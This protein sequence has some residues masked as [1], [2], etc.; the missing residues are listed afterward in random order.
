MVIDALAELFEKAIESE[1]KKVA[2]GVGLNLD[3]VEAK[4]GW[5]KEILGIQSEISNESLED[6]LGNSSGGR[7]YASRPI[8]DGELKAT[9]CLARD[10]DKIDHYKAFVTDSDIK[11]YKNV[12][13]VSEENYKDISVDVLHQLGL[14]FLAKPAGRKFI[15]NDF[16]PVVEFPKMPSSNKAFVNP[17]SGTIETKIP[18]RKILNESHIE[19][20]ESAVDY[21]SKELRHNP[22]DKMIFFA[23]ITFTVAFIFI[24]IFQLF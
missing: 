7:L 2:K 23:V 12:Q 10:G 21:I 24:K 16:S 3:S 22:F 14:I 13:L 11:V 4:D 17:E 20:G 9:A 1:V 19:A 5:L 8:R 18:P 15:N 6:Q